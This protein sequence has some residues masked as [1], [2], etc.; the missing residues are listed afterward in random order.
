MTTSV[1]IDKV[2]KILDLPALLILVVLCSIYDDLLF[3]FYFGC[4]LL[5]LASFVSLFQEPWP[6]S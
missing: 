3:L 2:L 5:C 4:A 1:S 6:V